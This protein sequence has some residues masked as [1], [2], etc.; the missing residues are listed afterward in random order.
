MFAI[1]PLPIF[2]GSPE[3]PVAVAARTASATFASPSRLPSGFAEPVAV[4][5]G[6]EV[7]TVAGPRGPDDYVGGD[8][9]AGVRL[10]VAVGRLNG[11]LHRVQIG[12]VTATRTL[13]AA[14]NDHGDAAVLFSRCRGR[15]CATTSVWA[16]FRRHG[17]AFGA[18][19]A[20]A[21]KTYRA[22]GSVTLNASGDA[23]LAWEQNAPGTRYRNVLTRLRTAKGQ[24]SAPSARP[25]PH[26]RSR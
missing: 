5:S 2:P 4:S 1:G 3:V 10:R 20:L 12:R 7:I 14:L 23:L 16:I 11:P 6:G 8:S 15:N 24:P 13:A 19:L 21:R 22:A 9:G 25:R 17:G 18:P 26:R